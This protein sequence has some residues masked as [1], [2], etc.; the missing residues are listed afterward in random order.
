MCRTT[1]AAIPVSNDRADID[2]SKFED[3]GW[4]PCFV[5]RDEQISE[6]N[7]LHFLRSHLINSSAISCRPKAWN[8]D[9]RQPFDRQLFANGIALRSTGS[10]RVAG[11]C[12]LSALER[13]PGHTSRSNAAI[14]LPTIVEV[15]HSCCYSIVSYRRC[16]A[17]NAIQH[18]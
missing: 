18:E 9:R 10:T 2:R 3:K 1:E 15:Y 17:H 5:T 16:Q 6:V 11:N 12:N 14:S 4:G 7:V 8:G 13:L